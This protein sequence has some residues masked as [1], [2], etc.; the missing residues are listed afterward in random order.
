MKYVFIL[1]C[2]PEENG[3]VTYIGGNKDSKVIT[4]SSVENA[5]AIARELYLNNEVDLIEMCGAF[6]EAGCRKVIAATD[7]KIAVG[8]VVHTPEQDGHFKGLFG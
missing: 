6:E 8:Y 1:M 5:C 7:N 4:A 3:K 2:A